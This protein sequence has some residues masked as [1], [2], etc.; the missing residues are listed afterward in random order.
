MLPFQLDTYLA[1]TVARPRDTVCSVGI[2][3]RTL[4]FTAPIL[5]SAI[6]DMPSRSMNTAPNSRPTIII[7]GTTTIRRVL[8]LER[9][10]GQI[11][12]TLTITEGFLTSI[13]RVKH[14]PTRSTTRDS[15]RQMCWKFGL[16]GVTAVMFSLSR[17][18]ILGPD[19][20]PVD[21]GGGSV[22]NNTRNSLARIPLRWMIRQCFLAN[23]GIQFYLDSFKEVGLDPSTLYPIVAKTRPP[24][25]KPSCP[26]NYQCQGFWSCCRAD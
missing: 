8:S 21:I 20:G 13:T 23:T 17:R 22:E 9:C 24:A 4:P 26:S 5:P 14:N 3:P 11:N 15:R 10:R 7:F 12:A 25:L 19:H 2:V 6:S 16:L 18:S 1:P